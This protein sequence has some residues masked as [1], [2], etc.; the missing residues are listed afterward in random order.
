[1]FVV[2]FLLICCWNV[3]EFE[4]TEDRDQGLII[5]TDVLRINLGWLA[6]GITLQMQWITRRKYAASYVLLQLQNCS[7]L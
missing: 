1:M 3:S 2:N 6:M 5:Q 4:A 7:S